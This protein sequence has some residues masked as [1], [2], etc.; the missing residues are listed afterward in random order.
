VLLVCDD[1]DTNHLAVVERAADG[2]W[3]DVQALP[4]PV[5]FYSDGSLV[6][7]DGDALPRV[8]GLAIVE[9]AGGP[10]GYVL[11]RDGA[12]TA[13]W[14]V[15]R[16][17]LAVP[18][19]AADAR[20]WQ[21][22]GRSFIRATGPG[23]IVTWTDADAGAAYALTSLDGGRSWGAVER[24]ALPH[25]AGGQIGAAIPAY[26]PV[27]DRLIAVWSCCAGGVLNPAL[28]T[29]YG[30]W[31]VPGSGVWQPEPLAAPIPLVLGAHTASLTVGAQTRNSRAVWLAWVEGLNRIEVRSLDL[32]QIVPVDAYP[33]V[34]PRATRSVT[35]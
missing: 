19:A 22:H 4:A 13:P 23:V 7:V 5:R 18:D 28:A 6:L 3:Q 24:I 2:A 21:L 14:Q 35:P 9:G 15:A 8:V 26:D 11:H 17:P 10:V 20:M 1:G 33:I 29:H 25:A 32:D 31:T 27:A 12:A 30:S 34:T 16:I